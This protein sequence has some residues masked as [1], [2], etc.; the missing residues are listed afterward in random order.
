[1]TWLCEKLSLPDPGIRPA[2]APEVVEKQADAHLEHLLER[3]RLPLAGVS[4]EALKVIHTSRWGEQM[5]LEGMLE[6][7]AMHPQRHRF[8]LEE[9][10]EP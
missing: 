1:M 5:S 2:P 4:E 10:M 7:A 8:Q 6:H 9:L 3:W